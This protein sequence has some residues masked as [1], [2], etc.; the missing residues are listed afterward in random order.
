MHEKTFHIAI[1][2]IGSLVVF[3]SLFLSL[4]KR[5]NSY[6]PETKYF[7][8]CPLFATIMSIKTLLLIG[9]IIEFSTDLILL[10]ITIYSFD[11]FFWMF[12]FF[13]YFGKT[14]HPNKLIL[15]V[16]I[17]SSVYIPVLVY[18]LFN[19]HNYHYQRVLHYTILFF[20]GISYYYSIFNEPPKKELARDGNFWINNGLFINSVVSIPVLLGTNYMFISKNVNFYFILFPL[21]NLAII[22]MHLFFIKG[23]K[24]F[25]ITEINKENS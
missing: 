20:L 22:I 25:I 5:R 6:T 15:V 19:S 12:Y 9:G 4:G 2:I 14:L 3:I 10:E 13:R 16:F 17:F 24:F 23:Y 1:I 11:F 18:T 21:S 7:F 8:L